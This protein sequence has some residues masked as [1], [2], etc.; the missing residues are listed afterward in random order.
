ML[1]THAMQKQRTACLLPA[2]L[3][4]S[5]LLHVCLEMG[6]NAAGKPT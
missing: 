1:H 3:H 2:L 6:P 4:R 5:C